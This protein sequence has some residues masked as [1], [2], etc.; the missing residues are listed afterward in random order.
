MHATSLFHLISFATFVQFCKGETGD[1]LSSETAPSGRLVEKVEWNDTEK[2]FILI[3]YP[4]GFTN[5]KLY[6]LNFWFPGTS[7][8]PGPGIA[9]EN[10]DYI[11]VCLSYLSKTQFPP[12]GYAREHWAMCRGVEARLLARRNFA[13][14]QRIVS[15]VSKGGWLAF[16]TSLEHP[17]GLNGVVIVA[18]GALPHEKRFPKLGKSAM[19]VLVCTGETDV[20]YPF[21][22]MAEGYYQTCGLPEYT[23][24]EWLTL[25]HVNSISERVNEWLDVQAKRRESKEALQSYCDTLITTRIRECEA[26]ASPVEQY[27]S[28][29]H[30]LKSPAAAHVKSGLREQMLAKG[31]ELGSQESVAAWLK[32]YNILRKI[33]Q[34]EVRIYKETAVTAKSLEELK[35]HFVKLAQTTK[36]QDLKIRAA[37]G[38]LRITKAHAV[39]LLKE[40]DSKSQDYVKL[41]KELVALRDRWNGQKTRDPIL[42]EQF[43]Q[44]ANE[45]AQRNNDIAM[46][47]FRK[48]EWHH[49]YTLDDPQMK[50]LLE[51]G[52]RTSKQAVAYTGVSY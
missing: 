44:K 12:G 50:T 30:H 28:L 52:K 26:M 39:A 21:A 25:G 13:V 19:P 31:R 3:S 43:Q 47:A 15:G 35:G 51:E 37:Y 16:E 1:V 2:G 38:Y 48:V 4:P 6:H 5:G 42:L 10:D 45:L 46:D 32:D 18:A 22:Q 11:E 29:R 17:Q 24:E 27:I 7:G 8:H 9:D 14:G 34:A 33:V 36:W 23:Y 49:Q 20:N 41:E 40:Q